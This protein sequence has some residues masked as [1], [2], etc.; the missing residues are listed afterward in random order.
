L[1]RTVDD[2]LTFATG[3]VQLDEEGEEL[4][5]RFAIRLTQAIHRPVRAIAA[6][7]YPAVS[8][9]MA[10]GEAQLAWLPPAI[11]VRLETLTR[12]ALLAAVERAQGSG[13]RGVLFVPASSEI[14]ELAE[15][16]GRR[17]GWVDPDSCA[18]YLFP[19]LAVRAAKLD[20]DRL[21]AE[22]RFLGSHGSVVNA[23][24]RGDVDAG[25]TYGQTDGAK[26]V[27]AGW[28]PYVGAAGMRAVQISD[29]IPSDV[30]CAS[31]RLGPDALDAIREALLALHEDDGELLD[32][33][34]GGRRLVGARSPD[35]DAVRA[36][37]M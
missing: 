29:P 13:Y 23:V 14:R 18:G 17:V 5:R 31:S 28:Y 37:I 27:I 6:A 2:T 10:D 8:K 12:V 22:Q 7:S 21:F 33:L 25:A 26:L 32:E 24:S 30:I 19:R 4:R 1:I 15:L 35:Y 11:F 3:P 34:F 20:P 36:A 9:L 16:E